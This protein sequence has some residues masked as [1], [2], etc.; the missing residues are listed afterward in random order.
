MVVQHLFMERG[1]EVAD[2][3][4]ETTN[5]SIQLSIHVME[6]ISATD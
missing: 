2:L 6:M 1:G 5:E 3:K 4:I